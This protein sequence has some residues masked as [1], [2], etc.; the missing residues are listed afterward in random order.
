VLFESILPVETTMETKRPGEAAVQYDDVRGETAADMADNISSLDNAAR[1]LGF[2]INGTI[3]GISMYSSP[4]LDDDVHVTVQA[5]D[6]GSWAAI[7]A[8]TDASG[9]VLKVTEHAKEV[10][11][12]NFVKCFKRLQVSLF[13]KGHE[14]RQ[15]E[16][17]HAGSD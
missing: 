2:K 9:G 17:S 11:L 5:F 8:A 1:E 6:G 3:V 12:A 16:V 7:K 15:L 14:I 4:A 13:T 10:P